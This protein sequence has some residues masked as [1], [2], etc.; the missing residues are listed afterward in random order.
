MTGLNRNYKMAAINISSTMEMSMP[1]IPL[2]SPIIAKVFL[3]V[4]LMIFADKTIA[5]SENKIDTNQRPGT[6]YTQSGI[7]SRP[8]TPNTNPTVAV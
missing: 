7:K 5:A 2:I 6:K 4:L 3:L 8:R 1:K